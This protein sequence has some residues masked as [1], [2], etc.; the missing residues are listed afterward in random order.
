VVGPLA[1]SAV[2]LALAL[3]VMAGSDEIDGVGSHNRWRCFS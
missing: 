3:D 2:D 1:R